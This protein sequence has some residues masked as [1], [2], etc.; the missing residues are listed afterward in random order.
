M[1]SH[2]AASGSKTL[3]LLFPWIMMTLIVLTHI[4]IYSPYLHYKVFG[5]V[6][7]Q[8]KIIH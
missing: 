5:M 2:N 8:M 3:L 7:H 4:L 1:N 6:I